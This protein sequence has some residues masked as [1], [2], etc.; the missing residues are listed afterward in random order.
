MKTENVLIID[1]SGRQNGYTK[2]QIEYFKDFCDCENIATF[3]LFKEEFNFCDGCNFCEENE[4]CRHRDLDEFF[5]IFEKAD[6]IVF[7]SPIY[8]GTFSAPLK[9]LLDRFQVYYTYFYKHNKTQKIKKRRIAILLASSGRVGASTLKFMEEQLNFACSVLNIE[10][11][12]SSLCNFTDT[13]PRLEK[14]KNKIKT[15]V[16]RIENL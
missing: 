13:V 10:F 15:I 14:T 12:E 8:N 1:G 3:E 16:E 4:K 11:L 9:A 2:K 7:A 6:L 5:E